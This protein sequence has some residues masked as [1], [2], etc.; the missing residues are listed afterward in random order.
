MINYVA[1][2]KALHGQSEADGLDA[3]TRAE[4]DAIVAQGPVKPAKPSKSDKEADKFWAQMRQLESDIPADMEAKGI[5]PHSAQGHE[6]FVALRTL[7][8]KPSKRAASRR[9]PKKA[10]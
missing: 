1:L 10:R 8:E 5:D 4:Y 2:D 7:G 6:Y 3:E 9:K